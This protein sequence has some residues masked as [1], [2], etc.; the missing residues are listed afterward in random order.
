MYDRSVMNEC[1]VYL[2]MVAK[3]CWTGRVYK[4]DTRKLKWN[5]GETQSEYVIGE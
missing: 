4:R 3:L 1:V 5:E 2:L